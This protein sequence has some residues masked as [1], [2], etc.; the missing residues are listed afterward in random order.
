MSD[1]EGVTGQAQPLPTDPNATK[2]ME[3]P[4]ALRGL[5]PGDTVGRYQIRSLLGAGG[6]GV[7]FTAFDPELE[8]IVA[9]KLIRPEGKSPS[10]RAR[11]RLLREAQA[12]AKLQHPNVVTV[13]DVG[14]QGDQVFIAMEL[15]DRADA[16]RLARGG[17][18]VLARD[19]RRLPRR[20][21]RAGGGARRRASST[22]TSS[23][24]TSSSPPIASSSSTS[25]WRSPL[26]RRP[27]PS[28]AAPA[29]RR[30]DPRAST[31]R[32][33]A[34]GSAR[35]ATWRPSSTPAPR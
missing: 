29:A 34:S 10:S 5:G 25:A 24:A 2:V 8:R 1:T 35:R 30:L 14:T 27:A 3:E 33:P 21:A 20:R 26:R 28:A 19:P 23:R 11:T 31:S 16:E 17:A 7:V 12:L 13:Y 22:A 6:M 4:G 15:V 9:L 32:S 18:A